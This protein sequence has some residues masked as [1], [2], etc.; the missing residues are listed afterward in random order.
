MNSVLAAILV[1]IFGA[2]LLFLQFITLLS[3]HDVEQRNAN[4]DANPYFMRKVCAAS[5]P[6]DVTDL[7]QEDDAQRLAFKRVNFCM[8]NAPRCE[9]IQKIKNAMS[10]D[11]EIRALLPNAALITLT[12]FYK[13]YV[14]SCGYALGGPTVQVSD[15]G[16]SD[17]I[18]P[19]DP[20]YVSSK[21]GTNDTFLPILVTVCS[22]R[23][24]TTGTSEGAVACKAL[25]DLM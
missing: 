14:L 10:S 22:N 13:K 15:R 4:L 20:N 2:V 12:K 17:G 5:Q 6:T 24:G 21:P 7:A 25:K 1:L 18:N 9:I 8:V 11:T 3:F 16:T 19:N 23:F